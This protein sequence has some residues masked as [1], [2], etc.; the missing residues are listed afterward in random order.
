MYENKSCL[1]LIFSSL[2]IY[3]YISAQCVCPNPRGNRW[4]SR[5]CLYHLLSLSC[6]IRSHQLQFLLC[7]L[8]L[9]GCTFNPPFIFSSLTSRVKFAACGFGATS[10]FLV[11]GR[12]CGWY[13]MQLFQGSLWLYGEFLVVLA[14]Q[15]A[16]R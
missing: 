2:S 11:W 4:M 8:C 3:I 7:N 10:P 1:Y 6:A 12:I 9:R 13:W 16:K 5:E 15:T 14:N